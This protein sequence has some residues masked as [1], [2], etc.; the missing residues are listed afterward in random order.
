MW[1]VKCCF[2]LFMVEHGRQSPAWWKLPLA[3]LHTV[4]LVAG[5]ALWKAV[6]PAQVKRGQD[7]GQQWGQWPLYGL[8]EGVRVCK[9][10]GDEDV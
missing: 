6:S 3:P 7:R 8:E 4:H 10:C 5:E 9:S 1:E 2:L